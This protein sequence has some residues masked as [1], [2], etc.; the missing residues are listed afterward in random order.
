MDL[1]KEAAMKDLGKTAAAKNDGNFFSFSN[2]Q[3]MSQEQSRDEGTEIKD[4][5]EKKAKKKRTTVRT[6]I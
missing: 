2:Q 4:L 6:A 3:K 1:T 5:K